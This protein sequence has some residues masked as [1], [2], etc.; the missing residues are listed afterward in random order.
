LAQL[1]QKT[2]ED[3]L[4]TVRKLLL[5]IYFNFTR[6]RKKSGAKQQKEQAKGAYQFLRFFFYYFK[7]QKRNRGKPII[8]FNIKSISQKKPAITKAPMATK[9][10]KP[11]SSEKKATHIFFSDS[12]EDELPTVLKKMEL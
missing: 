2:G 11:N 8:L 7:Y 12:D 1:K 10:K 6:Y 9:G 3:E 4:P 5:E